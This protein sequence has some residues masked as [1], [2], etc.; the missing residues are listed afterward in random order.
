[1]KHQE[2][3]EL[4][5]K[6]LAGYIKYKAAHVIETLGLPR[7]HVED[8][9][10]EL[11]IH[12]WGKQPDWN[13][14]LGTWNSFGKMVVDQRAR[15]FIDECTAQKRDCR[16]TCSMN[17]PIPLNGVNESPLFSQHQNQTRFK[18]PSTTEATHFRVDLERFLQRLPEGL[19]AVALAFQMMSAPEVARAFGVSESTAKRYKKNL[20]QR[21]AR[22]GFQDYFRF[23]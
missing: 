21:L 3:R 5:G 10:Q 8:L 14:T 17:D 19:A 20:R 1:M 18:A 4:F 22:S 23:A 9:E 2:I 13:Q 12:L 7:H 15:N 11:I 16:K 6:Y